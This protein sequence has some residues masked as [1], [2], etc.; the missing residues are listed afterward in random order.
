M[1]QIRVRSIKLRRWFPPG[2]PVA[3]GV[4]TLCILREDFV[5][6]LQGIMS[7]DL[8]PL[9][10]NESSYRR[11]YFWRNSLR[12]L[13]EIRKTF[14]A[15]NGVPEFRAAIAR[16]PEIG[17]VFANAQRSLSRASTKFL[18]ELRN[19]LGGHIDPARIQQGLNSL[20]V[21]QEGFAQLGTTR[22]KTHYKFAQ[23]ILWTA[24]L[25]NLDGCSCQSAAEKMLSDTASLTNVLT[26]V[27]DVIAW[28]VRGRRLQ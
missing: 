11:T 18:R 22:E 1:T 12:T 21:Q 6:E 14:N 17:T 3:A 26:A 7:D 9:D 16:E 13:E 28:Y 24:I 20:E 27:D 23:D 15:L 10:G 5:L 19:E 4:A 8:A 25:K 2:D